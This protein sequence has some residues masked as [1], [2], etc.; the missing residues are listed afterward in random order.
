MGSQGRRP[1]TFGE[2][3]ESCCAA[4]AATIR[5]RHDRKAETRGADGLNGLTPTPGSRAKQLSELEEHEPRRGGGLSD[6]SPDG[7]LT[8]SIDRE[9]LRITRI[10]SSDS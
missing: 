8:P 5:A 10:T 9:R 1:P 4:R 3:S 6:E 7:K 2:S